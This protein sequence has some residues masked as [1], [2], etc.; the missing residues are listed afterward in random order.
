MFRYQI[1]DITNFTIAR[2]AW[3]TTNV[4]N[5]FFNKLNVVNELLFFLDIL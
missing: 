1:L 5:L 2:L 3:I 4:R